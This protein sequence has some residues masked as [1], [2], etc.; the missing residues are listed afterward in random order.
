VGAPWDWAGRKQA[1]STEITEKE[2][3]IFMTIVPCKEK[4]VIISNALGFLTYLSIYRY[5]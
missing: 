1:S 3:L 2:Y 5:T 4:G